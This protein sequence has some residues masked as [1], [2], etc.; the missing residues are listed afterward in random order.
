MQKS[1]WLGL[2]I[3]AVAALGVVAGCA[4]TGGANGSAGLK[5]PSTRTVD[6]VDTYHG[7]RVADPYRWLEDD[8]SADTKAWVTAQNAVTEKHLSALPQ[9][10]PVRKLY[11]DLYNFEKFGLPYKEG[12]RYFWWRNDGLQQQNVVYTAATLEAPPVVALDPNSL[13]KDGTVAL[14]GTVPSKDGKLLAYGVAE[15]GSDWQTWR[16]R[17]LATGKDLPDVLRWVKFS[18]A[19]WTPDHQGFFYSRYDPPQ[20]GAALTG[21]N[22]FQKLH[23]HRL[24]TDQITDVVVAQNAAEKAWGFSPDVSEDGKWLVIN[25]WKD[26]GRRNGLMVMPLVSGAFAQGKTQNLSMAFD[27]EYSV[28]GF[29]G[30]KLLVKTDK[31]AQ[32]GRIIAID[33]KDPASFNSSANWKTLVAAW[34]C[35]TCVMRPPK[36]VCTAPMARCNAKWP[37]PVS[38]RRVVLVGA[39]PA[40]KLS[41]ATPV[42]STPPRFGGTTWPL[43]P[44][45]FSNAHKPRLTRRNSKPGGPSS[46]A[47]TAPVCPS[48]LH[49]ARA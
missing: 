25:V 48:S 21:A 5:Y 39:W 26:T 24:G 16:V 29:N 8:N 36:C 46:Q 4:N 33:L 38:A 18:S 23:Y 19:V 1:E 37:C 28:I 3:A 45:A 2:M 12:G 13:S 43:V 47:K 17:D 32:R 6:Q 10:L 9:R 14:T 42:W 35:A 44:P 20:A 15:G 27:A 31:D 22:Y 41:S 7:T 49:T 40:P 11:T 30:D 34:C